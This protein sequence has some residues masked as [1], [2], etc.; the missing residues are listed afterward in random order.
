MKKC[1]K[2]VNEI[3]NFIKNNPV[4]DFKMDEKE[5]LY[6]INWICDDNEYEEGEIKIY[7]VLF[8]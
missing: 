1:E 4:E 5:T 7:D 6:Y 2:F 3:V 8:L